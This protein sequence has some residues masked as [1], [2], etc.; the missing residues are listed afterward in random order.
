[1]RRLL[2]WVLQNNVLLIQEEYSNIKI[3]EHTARL[4]DKISKV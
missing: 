2:K 4:T 1:M 3:L